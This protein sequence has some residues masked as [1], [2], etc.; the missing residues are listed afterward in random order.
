MKFDH[1]S[2]LAYAET[3]QRGVPMRAEWIWQ[4]RGLEGEAEMYRKAVGAPSLRD[5]A[6]R[7][8]CTNTTSLTAQSLETVP[9][10]VGADL[11]AQITRK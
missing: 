8:V 3:I 1:D 9:W 2:G 7:C 11:W 5:T 6:I 10:Q 4:S